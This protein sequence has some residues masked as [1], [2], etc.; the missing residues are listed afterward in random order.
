MD[1]KR[2]EV[3]DK[4]IRLFNAT[5]RV[6]SGFERIIKQYVHSKTSC[7]VWAYVRH[8]SEQE[9]FSAKAVQTNET[10]LFKVGYSPKVTDDLFVEFND[11][12]YSIVSIDPF[13]YNKTD[14][15][16]R[17]NEVSPPPFDEVEYDKY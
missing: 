5:T 1:N 9:R 3:K 16:I 10:I 7:G 17:A 4:K 15:V 11:K 6:V 2:K 14:L 12:T 8:L 13:E